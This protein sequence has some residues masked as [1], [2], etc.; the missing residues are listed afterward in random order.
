MLKALPKKTLPSTSSSLK[1]F[2]GL[3][4]TRPRHNNK[5]K[6]QMRKLAILKMNTRLYF[7]VRGFFV[8]TSKVHKYLKKNLKKSSKDE[9]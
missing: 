4:K 9:N 3:L 7:M 6:K 5:S 1:Q 2:T 8:N